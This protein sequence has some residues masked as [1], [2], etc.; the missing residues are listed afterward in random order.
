LTGVYPV[1]RSEGLRPMLALA[2]RI[3]DVAVVT[4]IFTVLT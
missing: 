3:F 2:T 4:L 1:R